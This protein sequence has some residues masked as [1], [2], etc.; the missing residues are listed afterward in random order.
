[1][2][3]DKFQLH[4]VNHELTEFCAARIPEH[5]KSQVRLDFQ[6]EG[7]A[8]TLFENRIHYRI[9][10]QWTKA[11]IA[12]FRYN[13]GNKLWTLYWWRHTEKW[14]LYEVKEPTADFSN[15][16]AEVSNDPTGIFWG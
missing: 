9:P 2:A 10:N 13:T 15:L 16:L 8:V 12:Q 5:A 6:V 7:N 3:I 4:K 11:K 14:Y 1:M